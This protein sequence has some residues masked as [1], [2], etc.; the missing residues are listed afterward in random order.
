MIL[1]KLA[2]Q[3]KIVNTK[4]T[5]ETPDKSVL[6]YIGITPDQIDQIAKDV[7]LYASIAVTGIIVLFK[8]ADTVS[9]IAVK[10]THAN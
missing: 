5:P 8:V 2:V 4:N 9:Q 1:N 10:K 6:E 7:I 3:T